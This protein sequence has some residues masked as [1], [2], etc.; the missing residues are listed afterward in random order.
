MVMLLFE[1]GK[2]P[3]GIPRPLHLSNF[4]EAWELGN[5]GT[6]LS[7]SLLYVVDT[8]NGV[9]CNRYSLYPYLTIQGLLKTFTTKPYV[10]SATLKTPLFS[11][12]DKAQLL[13][14]HPPKL[15]FGESLPVEQLVES[16]FC[17]SRYWSITTLVKK[18]LPRHPSPKSI[19]G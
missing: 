1:L 19:L 5:F 3:L 18:N 15:S 11:D 10:S 2:N 7:N 13:T 17:V 14:T 6:P 16:Y 4:A 12:L 9:L 8:V